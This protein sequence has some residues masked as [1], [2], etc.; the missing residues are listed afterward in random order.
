MCR[1]VQLA[2]MDIG[3]WLRSLGL[4]QYELAFRDN[5]IDDTVLP[6]LT[7]EDLKELGI[8]I[9]G[10]RRKLLHAMD[11][12]EYAHLQLAQ[13][14]A[15]KQVVDQAMAF[16]KATPESLAAAYAVAAIPARYAVE[17][18]DWP[19]A[20]T[21]SLPPLAFAWEKFPGLQGIEWVILRGRSGGKR[22]GEGLSWL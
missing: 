19:Q 22:C 2:A 7:A 6:S 18:R 14:Q 8:G 3:G 12:L 16:R 13:D 17:R 21:L 20:A 4:G 15:A 10:D 11:Y 1:R 5:E 9:V